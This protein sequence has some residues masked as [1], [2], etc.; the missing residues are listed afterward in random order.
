MWQHVI[1]VPSL[2]LYWVGIPR[3]TLCVA[4]MCIS[5]LMADSFHEMSLLVQ[6]EMQLYSGANAAISH[7]VQVLDYSCL[8]RTADN[9]TGVGEA[10]FRRAGTDV[11]ESRAI[12]G[13]TASAQVTKHHG[14]SS[15]RR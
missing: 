15:G 2:S 7:V 1:L 8:A 12:S 11:Q 4:I 5:A 14:G 10:Y 9:P 6:L 3:H 13:C